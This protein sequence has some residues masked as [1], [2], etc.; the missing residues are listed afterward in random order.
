VYDTAVRPIIDQVL[1]GYNGTVFAYGQTA[2][3][4]T[5]TM[6]GP[7]N[8]QELQGMVP[9]ML[10]TIFTWIENS[11]M[12]NEFSV[13]IQMAEVYMEK[14]NDLLDP[15]KVD[16]S[17]RED[18]VNGPYIKDISD[19]WCLNEQDVYDLIV[20]GGKNR[21]IGA[22]KMNQ[23]SSRSHVVFTL[24]LRNNNHLMGKVKNSKL[25]LVDLAGSEAIGSSGTVGK[26]AKEGNSIN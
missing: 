12:E 4:K 10:R 8:D 14:I 11:S 25:H 13:V 24:S 5:H 19:H 7:V 22:S 9:R 15:V 18:K 20:K 23:K 1:D 3:G 16:L 26:R 21:H 17:I 6:Y 2:S